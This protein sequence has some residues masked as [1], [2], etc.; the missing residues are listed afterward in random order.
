MRQSTLSRRSLAA[1]GC[2]CLQT[3]RNHRA[4]PLQRQP[5]SNDV[6][7]QHP[8]LERSILGVL[9]TYVT[10]DTG[11]GAVHT[12]PSHG[13]DDFYTGQRYD[14]DPTCRVD[15]AGHIHVDP[16]AWPLPRRR[17]STA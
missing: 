1:A 3:G 5:R 7:F 9:A 15:A 14:L 10:A 13:A 6:T 11:T 4:R 16:A 17:P 12:A 8:F 2:R